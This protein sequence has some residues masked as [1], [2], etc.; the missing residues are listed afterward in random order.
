MWKN[1]DRSRIQRKIQV[2]YIPSCSPEASISARQ[3]GTGLRLVESLYCVLAFLEQRVIATQ[4]SRLDGPKPRL[5]TCGIVGLSKASKSH[6]EQTT[7]L[8]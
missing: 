8:P 5:A 3:P 2:L 1:Y 7:L 6:S 4:S